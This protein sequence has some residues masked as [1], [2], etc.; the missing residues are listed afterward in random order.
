MSDITCSRNMVDLELSRVSKMDPSGPEADTLPFG[1]CSSEDSQSDDPEHL[2][3]LTHMCVS[4]GEKPPGN[5]PAAERNPLLKH[6]SVYQFL[7]NAG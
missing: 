2:G 1:H 6:K 7:S 4:I 5:S 3:K